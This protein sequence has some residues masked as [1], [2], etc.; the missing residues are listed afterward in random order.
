LTLGVGLIMHNVFQ[1]YF[2]NKNI[3]KYFFI[4]FLII[5]FD[6]GCLF[7]NAECFSEIFLK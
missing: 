6:F 2:L 4:L 7:N 1:K 3:L 5:S